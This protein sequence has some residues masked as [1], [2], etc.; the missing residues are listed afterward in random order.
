MAERIYRGEPLPRLNANEFATGR[1]QTATVD[2][3]NVYDADA[4][5]LELDHHQPFFG[6]T[7]EELP[8][9]VEVT[10]RTFTPGFTDNLGTA[11]FFSWYSWEAA[12]LVLGFD[13]DRIPGV[14]PVEYRIDYMDEHPGVLARIETLADGEV[15]WEGQAVGLVNAGTAN[16]WHGDLDGRIDNPTYAK[17]AEWWTPETDV[18]VDRALES[19]VCY[20]GT[21]H[22]KGEIESMLQT[23]EGYYKGFGNGTAVE[24][25]EAEEQ[26]R[27]LYDEV[28][29]QMSRYADRLVV[30]LL[31]EHGWISKDDR[32]LRENFLMAYDGS[33]LSENPAAVE[34]HLRS[35]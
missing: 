20:A 34:K 11:T 23:F 30:I 5:D 2:L 28:S 14:E 7:A 24:Y 17:E 27:A 19:V 22:G 6:K 8:G 13:P 21:G 9:D 4:Q 33:I 3:W 12:G 10:S 1:V 26:V 18:D 29:D 32:D 35:R 25:M 15:R 31:E 16:K